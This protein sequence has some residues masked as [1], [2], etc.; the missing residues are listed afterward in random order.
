M[1][2]RLI[3]LAVALGLSC[4][5]YM[6]IGARGPLSFVIPFRGTKLAALILV[7]ASISTSTVLFQTVS[8]NRI[9]TP[10]I[11]G[12]DALYV[13]ILTGA[14]FFLGGMTVALVSA[15]LAFAVTACAMTLAALLLFSTLLQSAHNNL[16]RMILTGIVL[17]ALFRALTDFMQRL[18]APNEFAVIQV[19]SFARFTQIETDL[20]LL[21]AV[22]CAIAMVFAWRMRFALD[23]LTLGR[24]AAVNLGL[25]LQRV[26][27]QALILTAVLVAVSTALVG[28]V[29]FLGL[30]VVS[31]ARLVTPVE[32][33]G[34]I[35]ISA[36]LISAITLIGGQ[37][38]LE[39]VFHLST[40]LSVVIDLLGGAL[41][42]ILLLKRQRR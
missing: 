14:V 23:V 6:T 37:T 40:P 17:G 7:G 34:V 1:R 9:L 25:D 36:G 12:F 28:P 18:I 21:A 31:L 30:L 10:S 32:C 11:M 2:R 29:A 20:L 3:W 13:M 16:M 26:Q 41:F 4:I 8:Q 24:E 19:G 42:L 39:R 38:V 35:F 33:H 15:H 5:A 27:M 22:V